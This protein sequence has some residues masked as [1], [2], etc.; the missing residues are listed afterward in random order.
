MKNLLK[1]SIII[2]FLAGAMFLMPKVSSA[3]TNLTQKIICPISNK[4]EYLESI[5]N[6]I[7]RGRSAEKE[8]IIKGIIYDVTPKGIEEK[9]DEIIKDRPQLKEFREE[10][11]NGEK[12]YELENQGY[13]ARVFPVY[14]K[15]YS[16][17]IPLYISIHTNIFS[18]GVINSEGDMRSVLVHETKH[19]IDIYHGIF[20]DSNNDEAKQKGGLESEELF[21]QLLELRATYTQIKEFYNKDKTE[22]PDITADFKQETVIRYANAYQKLLEL[23][24][25]L[26]P[27]EKQA[28]R[29]QLQN[30]EDI[31]PVK[32]ES[33]EVYMEIKVSTEN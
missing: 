15:L 31:K 7:P 20:L 25:S 4:T 16:K 6:S 24:P 23:F 26:N 3:D 11:I 17:K 1:K 8:G 28:I 33:G 5:L 13:V 10:I 32:E 30:F 9:V 22:N 21:E 29:T 2:P 19:A 14:L 18:D 12:K 27:A